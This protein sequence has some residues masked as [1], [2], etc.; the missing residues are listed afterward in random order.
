MD[1]ETSKSYEDGCGKLMYDSWG[2]EAGLSWSER[3]VNKFAFKIE[4]EDQRQFYSKGSQSSR[5]PRKRKK[6]KL[7]S[8]QI[9][10]GSLKEFIHE[11][12]TS[13]RRQSIS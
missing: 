12:L 6:G 3:I 10:L 1:L 9:E 13:R 7:E 2:G 4:N 11:F 8:P 5:S